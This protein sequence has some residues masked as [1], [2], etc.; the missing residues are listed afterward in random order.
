[1]VVRETPTF[2]REIETLINKHNQEWG[3]NTPD[4]ILAEFLGRCLAAWNDAVNRREMWYGRPVAGGEGNE[5]KGN[6]TRDGD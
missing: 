4:F 3:S 1:M 5:T 6:V 2:I